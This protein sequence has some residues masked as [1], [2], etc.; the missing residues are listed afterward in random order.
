VLA[1]TV[2]LKPGGSA[3][4][5]ATALQNYITQLSELCPAVGRGKIVFS[6]FVYAR[7]HKSLSSPC[8]YGRFMITELRA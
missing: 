8:M 7:T 3:L 4:N 1:D 2:E 5:T 6:L